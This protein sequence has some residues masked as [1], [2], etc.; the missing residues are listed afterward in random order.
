MVD[1]EVTYLPSKSTIVY[2]VY[3]YYST[4][5]QL[6]CSSVLGHQSELAP[7]RTM[8]RY[9]ADWSIFYHAQRFLVFVMISISIHGTLNMHCFRGHR[10]PGG[11][12]AVSVRGDNLKLGYDEFISLL[13]SRVNAQMNACSFRFFF[14]P[15]ASSI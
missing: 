8:V 14:D 13:S 10:T 11:C 5:P 1:K 7:V 2:L 9:C 6:P 15:H 12:G 3:T 4:V